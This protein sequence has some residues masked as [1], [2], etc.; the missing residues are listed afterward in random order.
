MKSHD[1]IY[2]KNV[3]EMRILPIVNS[4]KVVESFNK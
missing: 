3:L 2:S 4:S 1:Y